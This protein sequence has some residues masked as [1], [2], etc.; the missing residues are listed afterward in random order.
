MA[1]L[2]QA[3]VMPAPEA[4]AHS[5]PAK[6]AASPRGP[7]DPY[8]AL[9]QLNPVERA[10][11][12]IHIEPGTTG[13][14]DALRE[15]ERLWNSGDHEAAL[16]EFRNLAG[17]IDLRNTFVGINW[18]TPAPTLPTDD[19]G[20]NVRVGNRDSIYCTAFDRNSVNGNLLV[21]LL[22]H[23]GTQTYID[24]NL[25]T[26]GGTTW[27]ETFDG[28]WSGVTPP[29]D[30]DGACVGTAFLVAYIFPDL[31]QVACVKIDAATGQWIQFPGGD[32]VDTVFTPAPAQVTEI[33]M[34]AAEEQWPGQRAYAFGRTDADS[35]LYAWTTGD[36][37]PWNRY[38]TTIDWCNAGMIDCVVNTGY[39]PGGNWLWA[40]WMYRRAGDTLHPAI[41]WMDEGGTWHAVYIGN[42]PTQTYSTSSLAAWHDTVFMAY[43][44]QLGGGFY[45]QAL[46]TYN[47][48]GTWYYTNVPDT[49]VSPEFPGAS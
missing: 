42:L 25:S 11:A 15:I 9:E 2:P 43:T 40:S 28:S 48:G 31:N 26:D 17:R 29:S 39:P 22:R 18:R 37:Q 14:A 6:P 44:H 46:V 41:A 33:S 30:L 16:T 36:G 4:P 35:L 34:C 27:T 7:A 5:Q 45:T 38:N 10:N 8:V 13:A 21:G 19:W 49:G 47:A 12:R 23:A 20:P 24:V 1:G 32:W 3:V